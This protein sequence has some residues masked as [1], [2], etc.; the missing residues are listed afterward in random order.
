MHPLTTT[1]ETITLDPDRWID[2]HGDA[3]YRYAML[4]VRDPDAAADL[5]QETF[6]EAFRNRD[7]YAGRSSERTWLVAI[8]RHRVIDHLRRE[9]RA[10]KQAPG[11]EQNS[12]SPACPFF[13]SRA[14]WQHTPGAWKDRPDRLLERREFWDV[15]ESCLGRL[16]SSLAMTFWLREIDGLSGE[17]VCL[18]TG[19]TP[20]NLWARLHRARLSLRDCLERHWFCDG[21]RTN[22]LAPAPDHAPDR[23]QS[24]R[25]GTD[26]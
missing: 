19:I 10:R 15:V 11:D 18:E 22:S 14:G 12:E 16:P 7:G 3:L 6:L 20:A 2:Q 13:N 1:G 5:V 9:R 23:S 25:P 24:T 17:E 26:L 4:R 21:G 8:L